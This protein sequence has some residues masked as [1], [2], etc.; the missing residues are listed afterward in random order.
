MKKPEWGA[1]HGRDQLQFTSHVAVRG[2]TAVFTAGV[3]IENARPKFLQL[4]L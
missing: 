2:I 4:L 3:G 1:R